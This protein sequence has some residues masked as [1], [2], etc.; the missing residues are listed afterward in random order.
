MRTQCPEAV[1]ATRYRPVA[2]LLLLVSVASVALGVVAV[3]VRATHVN[4]GGGPASDTF[5]GGS[6]NDR[7]QGNQYINV[8]AGQGGSDYLI[9]EGSA[10]TICGGDG[11]DRVSGDTGAGTPGADDIFLNENC[12]GASG[13]D[14]PDDIR[15]GAGNDT[16][17][18]GYGG[19]GTGEWGIGPGLYGGQGADQIW[20]DDGND[21][22]SGGDGANDWG[23]AGTG[24]DDT[25]TTSLET[26]ISCEY[27][28]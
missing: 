22:L 17:Y 2:R 23:D 1:S 8:M 13:L 19:C 11:Y 16:V 20:G 6:G 3:P 15:G 10:D 4:C 18:Q 24:S 14:E 5:T 26:G 28:I 9:G 27:W 21:Y 7:L 12:D 25:C